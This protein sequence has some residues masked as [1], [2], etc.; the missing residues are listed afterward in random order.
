MNTNEAARLLLDC[1]PRIYLACHQRHVRDPVDERVLSAHQAS[2]LSHLDD[3]EG[4]RLTDLAEHMGVTLSTMSLA[5][6]RLVR[7]GYVAR[8]QD[9]DDRRQIKLRLTPD[10]VRMKEAQTVLDESTVVRMLGRM[11]EDER[12]RALE[13]LRLL[14]AA[15]H[16]EMKSR[17]QRRRSA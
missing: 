16:E 4:T 8:E 13:G 2:I 1:Y 11:S 6:S 3:V 9:R 12:T 7:D 5:V 14:A 15:A 17:P 10:G